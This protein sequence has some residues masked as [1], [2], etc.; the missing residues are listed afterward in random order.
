MSSAVKRE[1]AAFAST[2][3]GQLSRRTREGQARVAEAVVEDE[4]DA[5]GAVARLG[6]RVVDA[7][8]RV[9]AGRPDG[10]GLGEVVGAGERAQVAV[11]GG[12]GMSAQYEQMQ[13]GGCNAIHFEFEPSSGTSSSSSTSSSSR[14]KAGG[15]RGSWPSLALRKS[16]SSW[17]I[18]FKS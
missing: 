16:R 7:E 6:R 12:I 5:V 4:E 11:A 2:Q 9:R 17:L 13:S 1:K 15:T 14:S 8:G 18:A 10:E 3:R